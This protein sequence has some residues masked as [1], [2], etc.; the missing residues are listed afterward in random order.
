MVAKPRRCR[1]RLPKPGFRIPAAYTGPVPEPLPPLLLSFD[2]E[3]W[4]QLVHR[5]HGLE[6]WERPGPAFERQMEA[7]LELL[8]ELRLSAT[9]FVLGATAA[10]YP[11]VI[12]ELAA[13]LPAPELEPRFHTLQPTHFW[14]SPENSYLTTTTGV[15]LLMEMTALRVHQDCVC[16]RFRT[17]L[18]LRSDL[19][20]PR[21][22]FMPVS[23]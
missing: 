18:A 10:A 15:L 17:D 16:A 13:E 19:A 14:I 6:D 2:V 22:Y 20:G 1:K 3:D 7:I 11:D 21:Q 8:A 9:F 4:H 5:A 23:P 12:R